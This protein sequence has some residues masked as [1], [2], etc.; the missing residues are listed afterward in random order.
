MKIHRLSFE[1]INSLKGTHTVSF[2]QAPLNNSGLFA[3]TGPT[4]AGKTTLLDVISLALYNRI[5]RVGSTI[6]RKVIQETG[7][8]LTRHCTEAYAEVEFSCGRGRFIS[9]WSISTAR[10]GKLRDYEMEV[11]DVAADALLDL[12]K[13][14]VPGEIAALVGLNYD[15]F[16]RSMVL[17]QGEFARFLKSDKNERGRLLEKITGSEIY[18]LLGRLAFEKNKTHGLVL[19]QLIGRQHSLQEVL[20]EEEAYE[21]LKASLEEVGLAVETTQ[22]AYEAAKLKTTQKRALTALLGDTTEAK[23]A[24]A[25]AQESIAAFEEE[26]GPVLQR[27]EG[28]LAYSEKLRSWKKEQEQLVDLQR[29]GAT[30]EENIIQTK[31]AYEKALSKVAALVNAQGTETWLLEALQ[32][33]EDEVLA[34]DQEIAQQRVEFKAIWNSALE[35][36]Q[37]IGVKIS[38]NDLVG[39]THSVMEYVTSLSR[40]EISLQETIPS[41]L[42]QHTEDALATLA[43]SDQPLRAWELSTQA[44]DQAATREDKLKGQWHDTAE[45][46]KD[47]PTQLLHLEQQEKTLGLELSLIKKEEE[48]QQLQ[49]KLE[50]YRKQLVS[51]EACPLCGSDTH[52]WATHLPANTL[53]TTAR[54][55]KEEELTACIRQLERTRQSIHAWKEQEEEW[56]TELALLATEIEKYSHEVLAAKEQIPGIL[57]RENPNS[58]R[59][60]WRLLQQQLTEW[61]TLQSKRE[62]AAKLTGI[63]DQLTSIMNAGKE[64]SQKR[65]E[66]YA[67]EDIRKEANALRTAV[68]NGRASKVAAENHQQQWSQTLKEKQQG[69]QE[70]EKALLRELN[71]LGY[72]ET[73]V[74]YRGLLPDSQYATLKNE[75]HQ[76]HQRESTL[77]ERLEQLAKRMETLPGEL[78]TISMESLEEQATLLQQELNEKQLQRDEVLATKANQDRDRA[79]LTSLQKAIEQQRAANEKWVLLKEYIGDAE[80]KRFSTFAQE[81]TLRHLVGLAN[82]RLD[83]L[84]SRYR[85]DMPEAEL[86]D[87]LM[88]RDQDMGGVLRSVKTLSGGESFL[89]SLSLALALSDLA[90]Q[91][92]EINSLFIDEGFGTLDPETLDLTLDTLEKLQA[93]G[94]KTIGVISHVDALKERITTQIQVIPNGQGHS[95]LTVAAL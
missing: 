38:A 34:L 83:H 80:G 51:G 30:I 49:A 25:Q 54:T 11:R 84:A 50:D 81:L 85:L 14:E 95:T 43:A 18:R 24:L 27:H 90:S 48:N 69:L 73:E 47:L 2:D 3:I 41:E 74:A 89:I 33:L 86:D 72:D 53:D 78:K 61:S 39:A 64:A 68:A 32:A 94:N 70:A 88:I 17:A 93:E 12:K 58:S 23:V 62:A 60:R 8:V 20:M 4:G 28:L 56:R 75:L 57:G 5:P 87:S 10:T 59:E 65:G 7:V 31:Q 45:K 71:P 1:N 42:T 36:S 67:G 91:D 76:Y 55:R 92:I 46:S 6:T 21:S 22:Q 13:S 52:P 37:S 82:R 77:A 15:Q 26:K 9:R 66:L 35:I 19:E 79:E 16:V 63:L 44:L 40:E 29:Q